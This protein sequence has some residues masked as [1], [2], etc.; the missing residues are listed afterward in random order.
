MTSEKA[1][2]DNQSSFRGWLSVITSAMFFFY[3][4]NQNALNG[5]LAEYYILKY[6][7]AGA[8]NYS[9]FTSMYLIGNVIMF[10]PAGLIL[11]KFSTKIV[12]ILSTL[13]MLI[14]VLG[15]ILVN[16]LTPAIIFMLVVGFGGAFALIAIMRIVANWFVMEKS[17]FPIAMAITLGMLGGTFGSSIGSIILNNSSGHT[18]QVSNLILGI[19][20]LIS[21]I[22]FVKDKPE[23]AS[24]NISDEETAN[25]P[26]GS[27]FMKVL[28]N[29]QNWFAGLYT[30]LLN[31]PIMVLVFSAGPAYII[32]VF[33]ENL[34]STAPS[35]MS[36]LLV[37][38][39]IG[40]PLLGKITDSMGSR[41]P[42]MMLCS[43]L[44][45]FIMLPM[46]YTG[47]NGTALII[48]FFV[49]GLITSAQNLGYPVIGES[50]DPALVATA[51]SLG[52]I[53]IMGGGAVAQNVF[54]FLINHYGYQGAYTMLPV[55]AFITL[56]LA[57]FIKNK[58][59][60]QGT[61]ALNN[62]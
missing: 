8:I 40:G 12:L 24:V 11:D 50:N 17:G 35:I 45:F 26:M 18:V 3:W 28:A 48:I 42:L 60:V 39:M 36:A 62:C 44:T 10:I 23:G 49:M 30:S 9:T 13:T 47:L 6:H 54:G 4:L 55:C 19:I 14:G 59:P 51:M 25:L 32:H 1:A 38:T 7:I 61:E 16:S 20:I 29:P 21:I 22:L 43:I 53:L 2:L 46:Y 15:L 27:S 33:G 52:S 34:K 37:G 31:F 56:F 41:K 57:I 58:I 5:T